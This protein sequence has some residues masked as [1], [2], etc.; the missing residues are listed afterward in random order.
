MSK[1]VDTSEVKSLLQYLTLEDIGNLKMEIE[2]GKE[3]NIHY[4]IDT[5]DVVRA[6]FPFGITREERRLKPD[7]RSPLLEH[8]LKIITDE[9][10]AYDYFF[11]K[12]KGSLLV[13][14]EYIDE[15]DAFSDYLKY[16]KGRDNLNDSGFESL[17][18]SL[19]QDSPSI[20]SWRDLENLNSFDISKFICLALGLVSLG[21]KKYNAAIE[22]KL[23]LK[24]DGLTK[25]MK[26]NFGDDSIAKLV[27]LTRPMN[28]STLT[29]YKLWNEINQGDSSDSN[30][31]TDCKALDRVLRLNKVCIEKK[32][33]HL[34]IFISS[35]NSM[36]RL[37]R[38]SYSLNSEMPKINK[39]VFN[40]IRSV[41]HLYGRKIIDAYLA[42]SQSSSLEYGLEYIEDLVLNLHKT[43]ISAD[44]KQRTYYEIEKI[45]ESYENFSLLQ[46]YESYRNVLKV[47][48]VAGKIQVH[49]NLV[50]SYN[51]LKQMANDKEMLLELESIVVQKVDYEINFKNILL[52][53]IKSIRDLGQVFQVKSGERD[54]IVGYFHLLPILIDTTNFQNSYRNTLNEV[55]S[56][57]MT[58]NHEQKHSKELIDFLQANIRRIFDRAEHPLEEILHHCIL[59]M[60][61]PN[62]SNEYFGY[63]VPSN[64]EFVMAKVNEIISN[65]VNL[66]SL[67]DNNSCM[68]LNYLYIGS[69][70]SRRLGEFSTARLLAEKGNELD[71]QDGRFFHSLSLIYYSMYFN[72]GMSN[73][74]YLKEAKKYCDNAIDLYVDSGNWSTN[75]LMPTIYA[76]RNTSLYIDILLNPKFNSSHLISW[77]FKIDKLKESMGSRYATH[78]EFL[79]TESRIY[80]DEAILEKS[81]SKLNLALELVNKTL[82]QMK[83]C[84]YLDKRRKLDMLK[85]CIEE[86]KQIL[87]SYDMI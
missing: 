41:Q 74:V 22:S 63:K 58:K 30:V 78:F 14:D 54:F 21:Y 69:W 85:I 84:N 82:S 23:I 11:D 12:I 61:L 8:E 20:N 1:Y 9:Q 53:G 13:L 24:Y 29:I 62:Y 52:K 39:Q 73:R 60:I 67:H 32:I 86:R 40:P 47:A 51:G 79:H 36:Q 76:L 28:E 27:D 83:A 4:F 19:A 50:E 81:R 75:L 37:S 80:F 70:V 3:Y 6:C 34:F 44:L 56:F 35:T 17:I 46:T 72:E 64:D 15:L 10:V 57:I 77:R 68:L 66:N 7:L 5:F 55:A 71:P 45:R 25:Y 31:Y 18:N 26:N 48:V 43:G 59:L 87:Q 38:R 65:K 49:P 16:H 2:L 33:P 42:N